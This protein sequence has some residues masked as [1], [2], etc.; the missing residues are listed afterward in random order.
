MLSYL[1]DFAASGLA[2]LMAHFK[3]IR[4]QPPRGVGGGIQPLHARGDD[5]VVLPTELSL[6]TTLARPLVR[7]SVGRNLQEHEPHDEFP[8]GGVV[9]MPNV[10]KYLRVGRRWIVTR[11]LIRELRVAVS[12]A[13]GR[14]AVKVYDGECV[15]AYRRVF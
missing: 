9:Y 6:P 4:V 14:L 3:N 2:F 12:V 1:L 10:W 13:L 8:W 11:A 5:A 7:D 15:L